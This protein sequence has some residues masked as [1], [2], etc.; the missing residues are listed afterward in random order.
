MNLVGNSSCLQNCQEIIIFGVELMWAV[1]QTKVQ[2]KV[3][4]MMKLE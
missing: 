3:R 4:N 1:N 2:V